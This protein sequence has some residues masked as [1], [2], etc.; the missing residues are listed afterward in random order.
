MAITLLKN[1]TIYDGTGNAPFVGDVLVEGDKIIDIAPQIQKSADKVIDCEGL[2]I[3]PGF[4]DAHSHNDFFI[5]DADA[6]KFFAPFIQQGITT[7]ITGNCGFSA[8]GTD[9]DSRHQSKVGGGLFPSPPPSSFVEFIKGAKDK[10]HLNIAPLVGH[11]TVRIG[12]SGMDAAPHTQAQIQEHLRHVNEAMENGALGGS[13]GLMYEPGM[14]SKKD[15]L[16][17]FASAIAKHDGILTVHPRACSK[18][19]LG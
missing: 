13:L 16:H 5:H 3:A 14:Y 9:K 12:T 17:A 18:V 19:A 6:E 1:G 10:L 2:C 11:G 4:I 7:Q 15:E 8:F